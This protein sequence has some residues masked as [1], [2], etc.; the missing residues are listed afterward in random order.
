VVRVTI[1][2]FRAHRESTEDTIIFIRKVLREIRL[3]ARI[4]V[5]HGP[6]TTGRL[7]ASI[8]DKGPFVDA[9]RIHGSVGTDLSYSRVVE[10]GSGLYGP[11]HSKYTIRPRPSQ[12]LGDPRGRRFMKFYWR[13]VGRVVYLEKVRHPGQRGKHFLLNAARIAARRYNMLFISHEL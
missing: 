2:Y 8:K 3:Q 6:Y 4:A 13:R 5:S 10:R 12:G 1:S 11:T 9:E 7:A